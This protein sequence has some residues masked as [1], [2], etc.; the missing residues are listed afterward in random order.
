MTEQTSWQHCDHHN[1]TAIGQ[2]E[3]VKGSQI[4]SATAGGQP[5]APPQCGA[6]PGKR[7]TERQWSTVHTAGS[8]ESGDQ[9]DQHR[10]CLQVDLSETPERREG[11]HSLIS[12][13]KLILRVCVRMYVCVCVCPSVCSL[14]KATVSVRLAPNLVSSIFGVQSSATSGRR[15][16]DALRLDA[17]CVHIR[18]TGTQKG[19]KFSFAHHSRVS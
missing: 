16:R 15:S 13:I 9:P 7:R 18:K 3:G 10:N 2:V 5:G 1:R 14:Y 8:R 17:N 6:S 4:A 11:V 19:S 12:Y